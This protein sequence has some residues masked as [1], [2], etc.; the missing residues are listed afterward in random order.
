[1][2]HGT[3]ASFELGHSRHSGGSRVLCRDLGLRDKYCLTQ[4][5]LIVQIQ[6]GDL[7]RWFRSQPF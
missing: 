4:R 7:N 1:M 5:C 2:K 3:K 6:V